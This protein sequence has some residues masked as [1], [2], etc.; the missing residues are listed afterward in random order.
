MIE[1][2]DSNKALDFGSRKAIVEERAKELFAALDANDVAR[3]IELADDETA[4]CVVAHE[5]AI[6]HAA[7]RCSIECIEA[8]LPYG[9]PAVYADPAV[10]GFD[11]TALH[12]AAAFGRADAVQLLLPHSEPD[13]RDGVGRTPLMRAARAG[14][15]EVVKILLPHCDANAV[16]ED[17]ETA[18]HYAAEGGWVESVQMLLPTTKP[19][20]RDW[21]GL[22]P[23]MR[24]ARPDWDLGWPAIVP[25][26][27][28]DLG[29][30]NPHAACVKALLSASD[31]AAADIL[32]RTALMLA[33]DDGNADAVAFLLPRSDAK[34]VDQGGNTALHF[35][36]RSLCLRCIEML[37]PVSNP[38]ARNCY[39]ETAAKTASRVPGM[40][41]HGEL[42]RR[43]EACVERLALYAA[44]QEAAEIASVVAEGEQAGRDPRNDVGVLTEQP[45]EYRISQSRETSGCGEKARRL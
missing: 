29:G 1:K 13:A 34:A 15:T 5:T 41:G 6:F 28:A 33:A 21:R 36:A 22:T 43:K 19:D 3:V 31:V 45:N 26:T 24:A 30:V 20:A 27:Q 23:L 14:V 16:D 12:A 35:A 9:D 2:T 38:T 4:R 10:E 7:Q 39:G 42:T 32:E 11:D 17:G 37:L 44:R 8:L 40:I 25:R 18:L